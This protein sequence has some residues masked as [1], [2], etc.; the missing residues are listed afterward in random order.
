MAGVLPK[1]LVLQAVILLL[2]LYWLPQPVLLLPH[3][4]A[5]VVEAVRQQ[6][7]L[8]SPGV[9]MCGEGYSSCTDNTKHSVRGIMTAAGA[10]RSIKHEEDSKHGVT[11]INTLPQVLDNH[12]AAQLD[13]TRTQLLYV[14]SPQPPDSRCV[15]EHCVRP[16]EPAEVRVVLHV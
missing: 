13:H 4:P 5:A 12:H 15:E 2:L 9:G 3:L 6:T 11:N 10:W 16:P 1:Y 8:Q 14:I 7:Q